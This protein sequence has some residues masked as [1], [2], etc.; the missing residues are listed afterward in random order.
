MNL[1][2]HGLN[3]GIELGNSYHNDQLQDVKADY[4]LAN[5]PFNDGS[6]GMR[7]RRNEILF[8]DW[9]RSASSFRGA[10]AGATFRGGK[11]AL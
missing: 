9:G 1:F 6:A 2:M 5:P 3:G 4:L 10:Q 11:R 7:E 8:I